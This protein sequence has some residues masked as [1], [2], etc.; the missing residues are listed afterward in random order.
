MD[1][2]E[3]PKLRLLK[4][5]L[6]PFIFSTIWRKG[7]SHSIPDALSRAPVNDPVPDDEI[8]NDDVQSFSRREVIHQVSKMQQFNDKS[9]TAST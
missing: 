2:V 3:N 4:E 6:S 9:R 7:R 8:A 5:L 1:A